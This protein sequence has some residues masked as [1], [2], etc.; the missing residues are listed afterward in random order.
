VTRSGTTSGFDGTPGRVVAGRYE[1]GRLLGA[2][3]MGRVYEAADR[4]LGIRVALK[5]L[6][7]ELTD[8]PSALERLRREALLARSIAHPSVCRVFDLGRE[9]TP[10]GPAYFLTMELIEGVPL[11]E[12]VLRRGPFPE[13]D[14]ARLGAQL[15]R[16]LAAVHAAGVV[17]RD[18][19]SSN[20]LLVGEAEAARVVLADFGLARSPMDPGGRLT[21]SG[22]LVGTP[23][24][25]SPEQLEGAPAT[26]ASDQF[27]LGAVLYEMATGRRPF[28]AGATGI[29]EVARR[30]YESPRPPRELRPEISTRLS[31]A[32]LRCLARRP[33]DRF[34]SATRV[35]ET[36][37]QIEVSPPPSEP[38]G[39]ERW[40]LV[41][42]ATAAVLIG[43]LTWGVHAFT[44]RSRE[45]GRA[46]RS[47]APA[48]DAPTTARDPRAVEL[49]ARARAGGPATVRLEMLR[50]AVVADAS[51]LE[52]WLE[53]G[54][55]AMQA[56]APELLGRDGYA[57]AERAYRRAL[58]L[59]PG[60]A[61]AERTLPVILVETGRA[62]EAA[63]WLAA[64]RRQRPSDARVTYNLAYALRY[65][66]LLED[67][68]RLGLEALARDP[69]L[70]ED[71]SWAFNT[72]LYLGET[73]AF[74]DSLPSRVDGFTSFYR[75]LA[76]LSGS[77]P[78]REARAT[79][80]LEEAYA[81]APGSS[82]GQLGKAM[83]LALRGDRE[84]GASLVAALEARGTADGETR[85][86]L[87]QAWAL[88]GEESR[89]ARSARAAVEHGFFCAPCLTA[90]PLLLRV[91]SRSDF[92]AAVAAART[93]S[94]AFAREWKEL[95][96]SGGGR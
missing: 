96:G 72:L 4:E 90:D 28:Q 61:R 15:A 82:Y 14:V 22:W 39:S 44:S 62:E 50:Q 57:Q 32:I 31:D 94:E 86:K 25:M 73:D 7:E 30:L 92:L 59:S 11:D 54:D 33:E 36:L 78:D 83:S 93:R 65:T 87:A 5:A 75:G 37:E 66:G 88:L 64:L 12:V 51:Y 67:S 35:A 26:P 52:A 89:S 38:A 74:L 60:N 48:V 3:G 80:L 53:L 70:K 77:R 10:G 95:A 63:L 46:G 20:V 13:A 55:A 34:E 91:R 8:D 27:S 24:S 56:A 40:A 81:L 47:T 19:K 45:V 79:G 69:R 58:E 41:A 49:V 71:A 16:G 1:L 6:R 23:E 29:T 9:D 21:Q 2:G 43:A 17:H 42:G 84:R 76:S 68:R 85:F 18:V